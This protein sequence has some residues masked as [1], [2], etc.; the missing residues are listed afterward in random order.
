[1]VKYIEEKGSP[2]SENC[3]GTLQNF[4][5]KE[6]MSINISEDLLNSSVKGRDKYVA[7]REETLADKIVRISATIHRNKLKNMKTITTTK[8]SQSCRHILKEISLNDRK[9]EIVRDRGVDTNILLNYDILHSPLLYTE[10]GHMAKPEKSLLLTEMEKLLFLT[11]YS[12][13]HTLN[14]AFTIDVMANLRGIPHKGLSR[15][16]DLL[17]LYFV[18]IERYMSFG[19]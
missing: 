16:S 10:D 18:T 14:S 8:S 5:T 15:F 17:S 7:F 11:N 3:S 2:L 9:I 19:R 6:L 4:V 13:K 1:M 12:Y